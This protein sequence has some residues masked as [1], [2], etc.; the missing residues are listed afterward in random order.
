VL[1]DGEGISTGKHRLR[2]IDT[3]H[4]PHAWECGYLMDDHSS[5]LLCGDFFTQGGSDLPPIKEGDILET[6]EAFRAQLDYFS[7]TKKARPMISRL[8]A[9]R[10]TTLACVHGRAWKGD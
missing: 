9:A 5:M 4:L 3:P 2:W 10:P 1:A 8:A 6:S 7:H